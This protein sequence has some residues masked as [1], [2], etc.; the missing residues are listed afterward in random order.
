MDAAAGVTRSGWWTGGALILGLALGLAGCRSVD[1]VVVK[2][3]RG[4]GGGAE[5]VDSGLGGGGTATGGTD[6]TGEA[7]GGTDGGDGGTDDGGG[8]GADDGG[9]GGDGGTTLPPEADCEDG[10]DNDEDG[11]VDCDDADCD[12]IAP[13]WWPAS[14]AHEGAFDFAGNR[15]TCETWFGDFDET[16][17]D[18]AT[19]YDA[20]L[21]A[22]PAGEG[23]PVCDRSYSG[24]LHYATNTCA[25]VVGGSY[26]SSAVIGFVFHSPT[27]WEVYGQADDGSWTSTPLVH[28]GGRFSFVTAEPLWVDTGDCDNDPLNAGTLTVTW[29]FS[30]AG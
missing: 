27:S 29:T 11:L 15:V 23:C 12:A 5:A 10:V 19:R 16:V 24:A 22:L 6:G 2:K 13:C 30:D 17:D 28:S 8:S 7:G 14:M 20:S 25:D 26:P 18:C 1:L 4:A 9:D 21:A 3:Q